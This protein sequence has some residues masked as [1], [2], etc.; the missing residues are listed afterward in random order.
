MSGEP[1]L[2]AGAQRLPFMT[3]WRVVRRLGKS[4]ISLVLHHQ[5]RIAL[6]TCDPQTA[7]PETSAHIT[8][9]LFPPPHGRCV[10]RRWV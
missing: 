8:L 7:L 9:T 4:W 3:A 10:V 5:Q 2:R 6:L 1:R